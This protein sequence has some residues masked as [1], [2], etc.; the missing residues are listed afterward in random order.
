VSDEFPVDLDDFLCATARLLALSG[1]RE[2]VRLLAAQDSLKPDCIDYD[3]WNGGQWTWR[4]DLTLSLQV[5]RGLEPN[6]R[7]TMES[8]IVTAMR[9]VISAIEAHHIGEVRIIMQV[10]KARAGWRSDALAWAQGQGTT[11]QGR[12]RSTNIAPFEHDGLLFRSQAEILLY[13][14]LKASG[15]TI[16]PLPVFV[17]GGAEFRRL[18]PDFVLV[19]RGLM[20]VVVVDGD[21]FHPE[22]PVDAHERLSVLSREGVHTERVRAEDCGS[23]E[24]A[25]ECAKK[26]IGILEKLAG[27]R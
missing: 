7:Q 13:R 26:L 5:F 15:I 14:A 6:D 8:R 18:E 19:H 9:E 10:P 27:N 24:K 3:N 21:A 23:K 22:A 4:F 1:M 2:E 20:M 11:N 25:D 12:A 17:R 16:A